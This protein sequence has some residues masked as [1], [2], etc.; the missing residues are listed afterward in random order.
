MPHWPEYEEIRDTL[1]EMG[2]HRTEADHAAF[3]RHE[4]DNEQPSLTALYV[5]DTT[6]AA[7][8]IETINK[9]RRCLGRYRLF[10]RGSGFSA[11][12]FPVPRM[13]GDGQRECGSGGCRGGGGDKCRGDVVRD[14]HC[15]VTNEIGIFPYLY[16]EIEPIPKLQVM[17]PKLRITH[18]ITTRVSG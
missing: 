1:G 13:G 18:D 2:Y 3:A 6:M 8:S 16:G 14:T 5:D 9:G 7:K 4:G 17:G 12:F 10:L 15:N 11:A